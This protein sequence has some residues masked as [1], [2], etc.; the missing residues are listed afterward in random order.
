MQQISLIPH[1]SYRIASHATSLVLPKS[2]EDVSRICLSGCEDL[3]VIGQGNNLI[4]SRNSYGPEVV[5][6]C[7]SLYRDTFRVISPS[8]FFVPAGMSLRELCLIASE[9]GLQGIERLWDIPSSIGGAI[10]MNAGAYG[11]DFNSIIEYVDIYDLRAKR[12]QRLDARELEASYRRTRFSSCKFELVLGACVKLQPHSPQALKREMREIGLVRRR[13]F[14]YETPNAGSIFKRPLNGDAASKMLDDCDL[15]GHS[16]GGASLS[17]KHAGF[18]VTN[19]V[20]TGDD[21][22]KL[23]DLCKSRIKNEYGVLLELE[24]IIV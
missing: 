3:Q 21:I 11:Q 4:L 7:M 22:L 16:I 10:A 6:I 17:T 8:S 5:F 13:R 2:R 18:C 12:F 1:N 19:S 24:Q 15:K 23:V 14:P 20:A 9:R